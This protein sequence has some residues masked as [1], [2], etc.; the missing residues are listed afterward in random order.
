MF[1]V[2]DHMGYF[3][4]FILAS[5]PGIILHRKLEFQEIH[6]LVRLLLFFVV[7]DSEH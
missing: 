7:L 5:N 2:W 4:D 3:Y 6:D 1:V